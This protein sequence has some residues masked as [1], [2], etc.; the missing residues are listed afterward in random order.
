MQ[1]I[2]TESEKLA[3]DMNANFSATDGVYVRLS[4]DQGM[5]NMEAGSWEELSEVTMQTH[6]YMMS[7]EIVQRIGKIAQAIR[8]KGSGVSRTIGIMFIK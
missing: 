6:K 5:Q 7:E 3:E 2:S 1:S 8:S 4:V